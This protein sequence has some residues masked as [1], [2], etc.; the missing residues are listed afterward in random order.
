MKEVFK[1]R[2]RRMMRGDEVWT[3][4]QAWGCPYHPKKYPRSTSIKAWGCPEAPSS[5]STKI[6]GHL[7]RHYI[8]V[9]S[10]ATCFSWSVFIFAF[11]FFVL[12]AA[13][14]GWTPTYFF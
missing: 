4:A 14:N 9:A 6:S 10:Y 1:C 3:K 12:F 8:F 7:S 2:E 5:S 11:S 13:I